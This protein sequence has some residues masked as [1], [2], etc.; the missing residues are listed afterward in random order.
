MD[1]LCLESPGWWET[2]PYSYLLGT[3][4]SRQSVLS[5]SLKES[6]E[7]YMLINQ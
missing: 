6:M 4:F 7:V 3:V 5:I 1:A 2:Q